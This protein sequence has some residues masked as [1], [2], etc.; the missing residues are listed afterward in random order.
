[1]TDKLD[2]FIKS[3]GATPEL[4]ASLLP[5]LLPQ[6]TVLESRTDVKAGHVRLDIKAKVKVGNVTKMLLCEIKAKGEPKYLLNAIGQLTLAVKRFPNAYP[7]VVAPTLSKEGRAVLREAGVGWLT[8]EG[9]IYL[10]F[11]TVFIERLATPQP[12]KELAKARLKM[13]KRCREPKATLAAV[14]ALLQETSYLPQRQRRLP[15]PF[16]ARASRIIRAL[17]EKPGQICT[18]RD[19]AKEADITLRLTELTIGKLNEKGYVKKEPGAIQLVKPKELLDAW[20]E[21]Y[22]FQEVNQQLYYYSLARNFDEFS[23]KLRTLPEDLQGNYRLTMYA[24]ASLIAPRIRFN[25]VHLY[26]KG[27]PEKWAKQLEINPVESGANTVLVLPFDKGI[28]D[29]EQKKKGLLVASNT[30]LYLDLYNLN[31]RAREQ[32]EALYQESM[33]R[34]EPGSLGARIKKARLERMGTRGTMTRQG[35]ADLV[36][37]SE[38]SVSA[39][40]ENETVPTPQQIARLARRLRKPVEYFQSSQKPS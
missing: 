13:A 15:L 33:A 4:V 10:K 31:D 22:K 28:F 14:R 36:G 32:A 21:I 30:Q 1:M 3:T 37:E 34:P 9:E 8:L 7:V 19:L 24:G 38:D 20:T 39:W 11:D 5:A 16:S 6:G 26:V 2:N 18:L 27:N 12:I 29:Y 25:E 23:S 17:L 40:E 35:L